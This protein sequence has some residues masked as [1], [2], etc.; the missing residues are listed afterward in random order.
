VLRQ[1]V[2]YVSQTHNLYIFWVRSGTFPKR[3]QNVQHM[4]SQSR[5]RNTFGLTFCSRAPTSPQRYG[6]VL[7]QRVCYVSQTNN[8]YI[9]WVRSGTF[10][11]RSQNVQDMTSQSRLTNTFGLTFCLRAP[12]SPQ[13][14]GNVLRQRVCYVSQTRLCTPSEYVLVRFK[15]VCRTY[16]KRRR[17]HVVC[18]R[19]F[20]HSAHVHRRRRH[21]IST[22]FMERCSVTITDPK[23]NVLVTLC[24]CWVVT[25]Q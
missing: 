15:N 9:F 3:S 11:K 7:R 17:N 5:L 1:R 25:R 10:P 22:L 6:D 14:Y 16:N 21:V 4:T 20:L 18:V 13:R 24:F 8:L 23:Q 2:C 12:T 19:F